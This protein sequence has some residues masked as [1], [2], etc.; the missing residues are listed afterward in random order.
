MNNSDLSRLIDNLKTLRTD[1]VKLEEEIPRAV[2]EQGFKRLQKEYSTT[3]QDPNITDINVV[4]TATQ[5]GYNL[6]A[7]GKDVVYEEFGTGDEGASNG[8]PWKGQT[9]FKLNPYN[10]GKTIR[11]ANE[12]SALHGI[13]SG[14]YWTYKKSDTIYYTQGVPSGKEL[15]RTANYLKD[16]VVKKIVSQKVGEIL[17]KV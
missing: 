9:N 16:E 6:T 12:F 1:I 10:S 5:K 3:I 17:S 14:K 4:L 2:G 15:Y 8:H 13:T 11:E 7:I